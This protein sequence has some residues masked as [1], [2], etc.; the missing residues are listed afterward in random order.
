MEHRLKDIFIITLATAIIAAAVFFFLVPSHL[1][2]GSISGL[3]VV[4]GNFLPLPISAITFIFN[5]IL[6]ILGFLLVGKEFGA[7]TIYTS[8]LLPTVL[9]IFEW[10]FPNYQSVMNDPFLDMVCYVFVVSVGLAML[11]TRNASS[12]GLDIVAKLLN[13]FFRMDMGKAMSLPGICVALSAA[14]IYD[15]KTVVLSILGTYLNGVILDHFIF[16]I[17][18]KRRVCI[19][20]PRFEDIRAFILYELHSG[21]T[22]YQS[23]GAYTEQPK[24]E[25]ICIVD[26]NEYKK[27]MQYMEKT[28]P[29]AF[30]TVYAV[31]EISYQ[32]KPQQIITPKESL[33]ARDH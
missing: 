25:I 20:S 13:K 9:A 24:R 11:F 2:V 19:I 6:L 23:I 15:I 28:D 5:A 3:A 21:A 17:G 30:V 32:P 10:I 18:R 26:D 22:I 16:G 29:T 33:S 31:S 7:K 27:L 14:L 12:G 1:A 4:A 8:V